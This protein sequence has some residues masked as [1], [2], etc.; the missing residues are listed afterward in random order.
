MGLIWN[1]TRPGAC[2]FF[3]GWQRAREG[4]N[5]MRSLEI[6]KFD[7]GKWCLGA[8]I[9]LASLFV[10]SSGAHAQG[11]AQSKTS[12]QAFDPHDFSGVWGGASIANMTKE[13]PPMTAW[14]L[15]KYKLAKTN[16]S[17]PPVTG[18]DDNDPVLHCEPPGIPRLYNGFAHPISFM[19]DKD[20]VVQMFEADSIYRV[21]YLNRQ[22]PEHGD[23]T[24]Y[25]DS[26]AHWEGNTLV[27][28]T[29]GFNDR[30]WL[31]TS[32]HPHS[33][34]MRMTERFT[35]IDHDHLKDVITIDDPVAY[36]KP[37]GGEKVWK[38]EPP[39][40]ELEEYVCSPTDEAQVI[41][42]VME[43]ESKPKQ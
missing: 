12:T 1:C 29:N 40:W 21:F 16:W 3:R 10:F 5:R 7:A 25:G 35:R 15:A 17:N 41:Q 42:K 9:A 33:D 31:D 19:M 32:G 8:G 43:P 13:E 37:W 22:H 14:G 38:L 26:I 34:Q 28:D 23:A 20:K 24:W 30:T 6:R 4:E 18:A 36:T 27:V 11:S 2:H 39:S